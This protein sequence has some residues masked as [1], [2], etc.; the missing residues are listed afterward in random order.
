MKCVF[1]ALFIAAVFA[2]DNGLALTPPM[3]WLAW[4]QFRCET[5]CVKH[6]DACISEKLFMD[7]TD[8]L[9]EDGWTDAGYNFYKNNKIYYVYRINV[10]DCWSTK[11]RD[12]NNVMTAD[13]IRFPSG[14][15][16][17]AKYVH[18]KGLLFGIYNDYGTKTC[19]GYIG[20]EG[21]LIKD[22]ETFASWDVD[23]LKMD[24]CYSQI[25]DQQDAYPAMSYFLNNTGRSIL[26]SCSWPAY[27]L[28]KDNYA[29][30]EYLP[31]YCNL[32]RNWDDIEA[33]WKSIKSII[34]KFG[35]N[36]VWGKYAGPGHWNDPD[37][38]VIGMEPGLNKEE[39]ET[40]MAIWAILAAPLYMTNDLRN[41]TSWAKEILINKE[42]I[43]VDQDVLGKQGYRV[44]ATEIDAQV[45]VRE[46]ANGEWAI[47]LMNRADEPMD[48][49]ATFSDFC[50]VK[51]FALRNLFTH[52]DI[53]VA[54]EK[55]TA[56]Q[57]PAHG[58][59]M[60]RAV[61]QSY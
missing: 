26:Y 3:G 27:A 53:G 7:M 52:M 24:G 30:Y 49:T 23:S 44:T 34:N 36:P 56:T 41:I 58:V 20:S 8:R 12:E 33:N 55:Y 57:I 50:K 11:E 47:A 29:Y 16:A 35:D 13:P 28:E 22:A 6:P 1:I 14:M 9:A 10:D 37:M 51:S 43:A 61:P 19:G 15:K 38:L 45:W 39:S 25:L 42:V 46:L 59:V 21:F 2:L 5:D 4:E 18:D 40:Q 48:I 17:L 60:L 54:T 32:W 31:P